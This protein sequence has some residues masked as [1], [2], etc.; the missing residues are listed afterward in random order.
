MHTLEAPQRDTD[1]T[2]RTQK[3]TQTMGDLNARFHSPGGEFEFVRP[4]RWR[5]ILTG[6]HVET[7]Y[8]YGEGR[9]RVFLDGGRTADADFV[10]SGREDDLDA[11]H[12]LFP[13]SSA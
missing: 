12:E 4:A 13:V 11:F 7:G 1:H 5:H 10:I 3:V 6:H 2:A 8:S 9:V